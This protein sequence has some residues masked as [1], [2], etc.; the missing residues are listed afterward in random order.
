MKITLGS[1]MKKKRMRRSL[2]TKH[3]SPIINTGSTLDGVA[4][5]YTVDRWRTTNKQQPDLFI[6]DDAHDEK[7]CK[8]AVLNATSTLKSMIGIFPGEDGI[9][10]NLISDK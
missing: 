3:A 2:F 9:Q 7:W 5:A 1:S 6:A 10:L 4:F 8:L